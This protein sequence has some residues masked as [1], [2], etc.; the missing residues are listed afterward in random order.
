MS[1]LLFFIDLFILI[2]LSFHVYKTLSALMI[3]A[4]KHEKLECKLNLR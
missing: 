1:W 2:Y 3:N 4:C